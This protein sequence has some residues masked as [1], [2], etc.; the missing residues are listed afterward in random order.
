MLSE[1]RDLSITQTD[2]EDIY[3]AY[4]G[5]GGGGDGSS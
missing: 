1:I 2:I 5:R 4:A 3:L